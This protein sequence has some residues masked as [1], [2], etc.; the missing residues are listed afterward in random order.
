MIPLPVPDK[1]NSYN[2]I[3]PP[4]P[5]GICEWASAQPEVPQ[6]G[7][8]E[9]SDGWG[10]ERFPS[11]PGPPGPRQVEAGSPGDPPGPV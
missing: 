6:R 3:P 11:A 1:Q 7:R 4:P 8:G 9:A 5:R 10:P 2:P